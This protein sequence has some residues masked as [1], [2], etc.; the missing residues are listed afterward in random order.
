MMAHGFAIVNT[1]P[2]KGQIV[3]RICPINPRL[4]ESNL[5]ET[6]QRLTEFGI[7]TTRD[8][9]LLRQISCGVNDESLN[10]CFIDRTNN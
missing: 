7:Q 5:R 1:I 4:S 3:I 10:S 9:S 6:L 2:V 8:M